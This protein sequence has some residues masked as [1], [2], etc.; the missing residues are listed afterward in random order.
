VRLLCSL[1]RSRLRADSAW[2]QCSPH[3][4]PGHCC[5]CLLACSSRPCGCPENRVS[6]SLKKKSIYSH[7]SHE[8]HL[9]YYIAIYIYI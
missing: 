2:R 4:W 5:F 8:S 1:D 6:A 9:Q 3:R 7:C